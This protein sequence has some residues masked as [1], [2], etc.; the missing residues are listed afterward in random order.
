MAGYGRRGRIG[1]LME[2][3][4][5]A[6]RARSDGAGTI[7]ASIILP[8]IIRDGHPIEA[9][10]P[11]AQTRWRQAAPPGRDREPGR[12]AALRYWPFAQLDGIQSI[13]DPPE[14]A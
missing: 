9:D 13:T 12:C 6:K 8:C 14:D 3:V 2:G 7:I 5:S 10:L 4:L 1:D 11:P